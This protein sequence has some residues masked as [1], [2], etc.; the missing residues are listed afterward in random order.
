MGDGD[1]GV[2]RRGLGRCN[3]VEV[4]MC[5]YFVVCMFCIIKKNINHK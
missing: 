1:G 4:C 3:V 5:L 2:N